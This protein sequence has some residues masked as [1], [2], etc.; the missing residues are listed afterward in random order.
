M[1]NPNMADLDTIADGMIEEMLAEIGRNRQQLV[2]RIAYDMRR[3][4][5][6]NVAKLIT[7][8][9]DWV[10]PQERKE[11]SRKRSTVN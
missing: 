5:V 10:K 7:Y 11:N 4:A 1:K 9:P 2:Y 6:R 8:G 3:A